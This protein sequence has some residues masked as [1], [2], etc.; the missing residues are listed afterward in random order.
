MGL[1]FR[2]TRLMGLPGFLMIWVGFP[3]WTIDCVWIGLYSMVVYYL[4]SC[5]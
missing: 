2:I 5:I 1:G 4:L 3:C